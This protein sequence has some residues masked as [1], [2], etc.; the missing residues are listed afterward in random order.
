MPLLSLS[1]A[2]VRRVVIYVSRAFVRRIKIKERL[3]YME[4]RI[5]KVVTYGEE[6]GKG[7]ARRREQRLTLSLACVAGDLEASAVVF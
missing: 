3:P 4:R 6:K 5:H 2:S 1:L 7:S